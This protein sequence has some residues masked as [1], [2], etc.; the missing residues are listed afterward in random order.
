MVH[1]GRGPCLLGGPPDP[2]V[3]EG[4]PECESLTAWRAAFA[5]E[6]GD[7]PAPPASRGH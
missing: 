3:G 7:G 5:E 2:G 1:S 4:K 6:P